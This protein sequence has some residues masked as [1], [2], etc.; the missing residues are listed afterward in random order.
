[1]SAALA[2]LLALAAPARAR[3]PTAAEQ[4]AALFRE[5]MSAKMRGDYEAALQDFNKALVLDDTLP[6]A[7]LARG[8]TSLDEVMAFSRMELDQQTMKDLALAIEE[9]PKNPLAL[10]A[11]ALARAINGER[12]GETLIARAGAAREQLPAY[13]YAAMGRYRLDDRDWKGAVTAYRQAYA[14]SPR[15]S[16]LREFI[17]RELIV[18]RDRIRLKREPAAPPPQQETPFEPQPFLEQLASQDP[19]ER[20]EAARQ[21]GRDGLVEAIDP[22]TPLLKDKELEVRASALQALGR[23]GASRAV[24]LIAPFLDDKSKLMRGL[25]VRALGDIASERG[26]KPLEDVVRREKEPLIAADAKK[27]LKAIDGAAYNLKMDMDALSD[28]LG[29]K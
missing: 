15:D 9:A 3:E 13:A 12:S 28:E 18:V 23:I 26:R 19:K 6:G 8:L 16:P 11:L 4:A 20:A 27:A 25:A 22:L 7:R 17:R 29:A 2:A 10:S 1:M 24:R 14:T 21:L 5:G